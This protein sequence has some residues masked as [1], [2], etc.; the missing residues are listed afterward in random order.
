MKLIGNTLWLILGGLEMAI[1]YEALGLV[2]CITIKRG[3][4]RCP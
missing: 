2:F 1:V 3:L 4:I